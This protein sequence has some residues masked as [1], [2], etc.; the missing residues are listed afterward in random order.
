MPIPLPSVVEVAGAIA[1][2]QVDDARFKILLDRYDNTAAA[3]RHYGL[4]L[5][6]AGDLHRAVRALI[7]AVS[8]GREDAAAWA[9]LGGVLIAAGQAIE[10]TACLET[11]LELDANKAMPWLQLAVLRKAAGEYDQA[12]AGY[13]ASLALDRSSADCWLGLGLLHM[14][15]RRFDDAIRPLREAV[16]RRGQD[17]AIHACLGEALFAIGAFTEA[18]S[19]FGQAVALRPDNRVFC[20]K[21]MQARFVAS[22]IDGTMAEAVAAVEREAPN[23]DEAL[24]ILR[25][26]FHLLS[27]FG[28]RAAAIRL[29]E[30]RLAREP[31]DAIQL[32]LL[33]ALKGEAMAQAPDAYVVGYFDQFAADFDH[34]LVAV[35]GYA[36]PRQLTAMIERYDVRPGSQPI[37]RVLDLGCGTGLAGAELARPGRLLTGVDLSPRMLDK[38]RERGCYSRLVEAEVAGFTGGEAPMS[39]DLVIAADVLIYFGDLARVFEAIGRVLT[40]GGLFALSIETTDN[41]QTTL[42][43]SGRFAHD[44]TGTVG[45]ARSA[46]LSPLECVA[47]TIRIEANCPARGALMLFERT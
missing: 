8:L 12:A 9:D 11:S 16:A 26:G 18:T 6:E 39:Y 23:R 13:E 21:L 32:Y 17:A 46:G 34:K 38:A 25:D 33:A 3:L 24:K 45:L 2:W 35:L 22:S 19:A 47:T 43:P 4:V 5:W 14:E 30:W 1:T 20:F 15:T 44:V 7:G 42:L 40:S 29:G 31:D 28:H 36:V 37:R 27:G 10:A 41:S